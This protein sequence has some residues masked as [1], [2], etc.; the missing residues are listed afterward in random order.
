MRSSA[1]VALALAAGA[2]AHYNGT[3]ISYTT[4]VVTA[5]TTYC[6]GATSLVHNSKTYTITSV[7]FSRFL[8]RQT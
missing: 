8:K 1:A 6:P 5:Y 4:E 2:T 7:C 3:G